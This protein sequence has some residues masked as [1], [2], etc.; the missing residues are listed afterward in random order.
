MINDRGMMKW[1]GMMLTEHVSMLKNYNQELKREP[2]PNLD[3]WD[4]DAIQHTL[5]MAIKSKA[6]TKVKLWRD[7]SFIYN[8]GIVEGVNLQKREIE[9][10]DPFYLLSLKLDEIVD[11]TIMD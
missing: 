8:R 1:Q 2:R 10:Q 9:L 3:E 6:D 7:G 11:V 5:D 4:Y